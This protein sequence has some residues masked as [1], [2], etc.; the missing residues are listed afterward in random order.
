MNW[1]IPDITENFDLKK[2][3]FLKSGLYAVSER[4]QLN[5]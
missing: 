4:A 3:Y 2:E 1:N 5:S